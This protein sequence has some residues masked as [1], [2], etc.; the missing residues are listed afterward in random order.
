MKKVLVFGGVGFLGYYLV[1]ELLSRKYV[2][3]VADIRN[4]EEF[5]SIVEFVH[6]DISLQQNVIKVFE[7]RE[8]EVVYN[9]AG[10]A[11]L[12]FAV[13]EPIKTMQ[14]NIV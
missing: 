12:D 1:K 10:F 13:K 4:E 9:L 2:V 3:T 5:N 7:N 11:N 14:L 6:C 8:F